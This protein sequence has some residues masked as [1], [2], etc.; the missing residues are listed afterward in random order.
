MTP[1]NVLRQTQELLSRVIL[2]GLSVKQFNLSDRKTSQ[3]VRLIGDL[4]STSALKNTPYDKIYTDVESKDAYH[5]KF[6]DGG[7]LAFQYKFDS[8]G[9]LLKHRLA[10]FPCST[11]PTIEEAP[12]LYLRDELYGDIILD[13]IV[14]FPIQIDYDPENYKDLLHPKCHLTLGQFDNCRIPVIGPVMPYPFLLFIVR[15]FYHKFYIK[16]KNNFDKKMPYVNIEKTI[17][18]LEQTLP[19]FSFGVSK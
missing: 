2:S 19:H 12:E 11:L 16:H 4:P 17:S 8:T 6:P 3:G 9:T 18:S 10:F 1:E 7:L 14:R 13:R 15:N 5:L